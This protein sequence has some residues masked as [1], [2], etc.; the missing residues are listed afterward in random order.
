MF[1]GGEVWLLTMMRELKKKGH[2]IYLI[3]RPNVPLMGKA[4][5]LGFK[6]FPLTMRSD[7]DPIILFK[8][9]RLM[10]QLKIDVVLTNMDKELRFGGLAARFAGVKAIIPRRGIDYPIKNTWIYR[11]AYN[12][13]ATGIIANS[14]STKKSVLKNS[15]WLNPDKIRVIYNGVD[16]VRFSSKPRTNLRKELKIDQN[17][18]LIGFVG[19]LNERKGV[20]TLLHAFRIFSKKKKATLLLVGTGSME[21]EC[22][23]LAETCPGNVVFTGYCE[24]ID[25]IMKA[26]DVLVLPSL[27]EGFGIVLIEAMSAGKPVIT[28]SVSNM[29][30]I[31]SQGIE[32]YLVPPD[33]ENKLSQ[34]FLKLIQ[35]PKR[36]IQMGNAGQKRVHEQFSLKKMVDDTEKYLLEFVAI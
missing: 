3:C 7:F 28:T 9:W 26:I 21:K 22:R 27:W 29:P 4:L 12:Y 1:G 16:I 11:F 2:Q 36:M 17:S 30:E 5:K 13:L 20:D 23:Q 15:P 34:A 32:G 6:V 14:Q 35:D 24:D 10:R 18:F 19:Q 31:V 25:E 8:T 33:D